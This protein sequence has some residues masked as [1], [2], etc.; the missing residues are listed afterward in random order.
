VIRN[1][2]FH[3]RRYT[4]RL[5]HAAKVVMHEVQCNRAFK[6]FN[7]FAESIGKPRESAHSHA[8]GQVLALDVAG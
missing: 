6:V 7:L 5:M 8:H 2:G 4:Q 3:S 1:T